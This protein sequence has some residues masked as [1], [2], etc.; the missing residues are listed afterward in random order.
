[1]RLLSVL[2]VILLEGFLAYKMGADS[3]RHKNLDADRNA[4]EWGCIV[5]S[6]NICSQL[7]DEDA[8]NCRE[9]ALVFC[10]K[11]AEDFEKFLTQS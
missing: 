1:M 4:A 5:G 9:E 3:T 7:E 6:G 11:A 10:P 8:A 2:F